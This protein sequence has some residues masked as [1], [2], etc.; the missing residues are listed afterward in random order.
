MR[1]GELANDLQ[2]TKWLK[3]VF[4]HGQHDAKKHGRR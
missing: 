1:I 4:K 3:Q 2:K